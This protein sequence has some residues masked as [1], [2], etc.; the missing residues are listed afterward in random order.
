M[1]HAVGRARPMCVVRRKFLPKV[2][3]VAVAERID[4]A[5]IDGLSAI[6]RILP[7]IRPSATVDL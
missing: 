6:V 3:R 4:D 1:F 7:R 2:D 5:E